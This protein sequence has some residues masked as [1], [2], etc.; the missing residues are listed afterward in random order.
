MI[1]GGLVKFSLNDYPAKTSA[2]I[3]T[4][5]CNFRCF[6]C[7]N[8]E[9]VLPEKYASEIP[10]DKIFSFLKSRRGK[11]DAVCITGGEPTQHS[12][13]PE[14]IKT[15]TGESGKYW[16]SNDEATVEIKGKDLLVVRAIVSVQLEV[17]KLMAQLRQ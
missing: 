3:F 13:L 17:Q 5:G 15:F 4:R 16:E 9:L 8:P 10:S 2:V 11:L 1:I 14:M 12:D 6:Y 7:H